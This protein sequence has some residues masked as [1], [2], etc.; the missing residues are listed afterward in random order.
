MKR[1]WNDD[2]VD[3]KEMHTQNPDTFS[4]P[5]SKLLDALKVGDSVKICNKLERFWVSICSINGDKITGRVDSVLELN[6]DKYTYGD[7]VEFHKKN[8]YDIHDK[9]GREQFLRA[10]EVYCQL[11]YNK[12]KL[13]KKTTKQAIDILMKAYAY[14]NE[15]STI[16]GFKL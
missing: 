14:Y 6:K 4:V 15:H 9:L 12:K 10:W 13:A 2:W 16:N 1:I 7:I 8:I 11:S 5:E 3:A